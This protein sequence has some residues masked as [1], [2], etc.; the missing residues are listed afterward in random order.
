MGLNDLITHEDPYHIHKSLG[1]FVIAHYFYQFNYYYYY[2]TM[3]LTFINMLPHL[4]LHISSFVFSSH[5]R[6]LTE[7]LA[8][9]IWEEL[10][11][12]SMILLIDRCFL[13]CFQITEYYL[14]F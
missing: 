4:L 10:R 14:F 13:Y 5:N 1:A 7:K 9:F 3:E 11:L 8:M 2:E 6:M 12:H